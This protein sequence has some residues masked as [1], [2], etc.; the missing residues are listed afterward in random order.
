MP[1]PKI[2]PEIRFQ[3]FFTKGRADD[4]WNWTGARAGGRHGAFSLA[5]HVEIGAHVFALEAHLGRKLKEGMWA[6][7]TCDN[8]ACVNPNHLYEGTG[9]N[10]AR[11]RV[12]RHPQGRGEKHFRSKISNYDMRV[13]AALRAS[14]AH[15]YK[16]LAE[17]FGISKGH[18]RKLATGYIRQDILSV[19]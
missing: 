4:C 11:D 5:H 2:A 6:L 16:E 1:Y 18:A 17:M 15:S 9:Q 14:N 8:C 12:E 3:K 19:Y 13:I 10:N 7:H